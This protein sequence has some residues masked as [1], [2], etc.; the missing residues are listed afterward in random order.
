MRPMILLQTSKDRGKSSDPTEQIPLYWLVNRDPYSGL[1]LSLNNWVIFHPKKNNQLKAHA[2]AL[3]SWLALP[4]GV[5]HCKCHIVRTELCRRN[6]QHSQRQMATA[7]SSARLQNYT[8]LWW[9]T[10]PSQENSKNHHSPRTNPRYE[11]DRVHHPWCNCRP[12]H[13]SQR[14]RMTILCQLVHCRVYMPEDL[15]HWLLARQ[16]RSLSTA[17][18]EPSS[19]HET[20]KSR[21]CLLEPRRRGIE[22][23]IWNLKSW[24][25]KSTPPM[26]TPPSNRRSQSFSLEKTDSLQ[27]SGGSHHSEGIHS[28]K[29][30]ASLPLKIGHPNR[31][32]YRSFQ[33]S[34]FRG[35]NVSFREGSKLVVWNSI[36]GIPKVPHP[37]H[38]FHFCL[39][40][41]YPNHKGP[42]PP[43]Y[44]C[45]TQSLHWKNMLHQNFG[46][47]LHS[48]RLQINN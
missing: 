21:K 14:T 25:P 35:E 43:I 46:E 42:K 40:D 1:L 27:P 45:L 19:S 29:L 36:W 47:G 5:H 39:S 32:V 30:T 23:C 37:F 11:S 3:S 18:R 7:T 2:H 12:S 28:L 9:R 13:L 6:F 15:C 8:H 48:F 31:K 20:P 16:S 17:T 22:F 34:I 38:P 24:E 10:L 26:P 33:P 44:P 41:K 4:W